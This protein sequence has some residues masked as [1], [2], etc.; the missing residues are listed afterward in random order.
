MSARQRGHH[1]VQQ[2]RSSLKGVEAYTLETAATFPRHSH[3]QFGIGVMLAGAHRSWSCVGH[4]EAGPGDVIMVNPGEVHDGAALGGGLRRWR[5]LYFDAGLVDEVLFTD[6]GALPDVVHPAAR[7]G[8]LAAQLHALFAAV[9]DVRAQPLQRDE[10]LLA[11]F[12]QIARRHIA[13]PLRKPPTHASVAKARQLLDDTIERSAT[14]ADLAALAG[15]SRFQLLRSFVRETGLTPHAYVLQRRLNAAKRLLAGGN[16]PA[17][18]AHTLGFAD[19][20]HLTRAFKRQFGV[21]P[22]QYRAAL[23]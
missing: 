3:D 23:R 17:A 13:R 8:R 2:H 10:R 19:Q 20:S 7:D 18:V 22:G 4:V 12:V 14:L 15:V 11:L 9:I 21:T 16:G 1:D 6:L 5:M